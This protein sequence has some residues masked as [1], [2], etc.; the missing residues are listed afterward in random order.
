[1][2]TFVWTAKLD[3]VN[4]H[5]LT[6]TTHMWVCVT[7]REREERTRSESFDCVLYVCK[8]R[9]ESE[10]KRDIYI[11]IYIYEYIHVYIYV[12]IYICIHRYIYI[13][14]HIYIYSC[15]HICIYTH[16]NIY[17]HISMDMYIC[18]IQ[19][20]QFWH[21]LCVCVCAC[22]CVCACVCVH[23]WKREH[24]RENK[25]LPLWLHLVFA[26]KSSKHA[27]LLTHKILTWISF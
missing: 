13:H 14:I 1:M 3:R 15:I 19:H 10:R 20:I 4:V 18:I 23:A 11:N 22:M 21:R 25:G 16:I 17:I 24:G 5:A 2:D 9:R 7:Q 8:S 6:C 26:C 27:C 12:Y